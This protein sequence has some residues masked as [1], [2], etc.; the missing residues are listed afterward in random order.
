MGM[1]DLSGG[2]Q[3]KAHVRVC[4]LP[5]LMVS[6]LSQPAVGQER[7]LAP[8][9]PSGVKAA[10]IIQN[11]TPYFLGAAVLAGV[12]GGILFFKNNSSTVSATGTSS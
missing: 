8:G 11:E 2:A 7:S 5:V 1:S 10:T 9:K 3:L 4:V 6:V 12:L